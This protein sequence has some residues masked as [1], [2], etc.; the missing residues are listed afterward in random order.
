M[1]HSVS[2]RILALQDRVP[3]MNTL[4]YPYFM[5]C[6]AFQPQKDLPTF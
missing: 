4:L 1:M 2:K 6:Y 5:T 3:K